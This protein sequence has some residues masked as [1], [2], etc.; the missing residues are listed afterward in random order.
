MIKWINTDLPKYEDPDIEIIE[1]LSVLNSI[2]KGRIAFDYETTG[3]KP[4]ATGH[5]IICASVADSSD[6]AFVFMM[7]STRKERQP[8]ID[9]LKNPNVGK[10]AQNMKFE[11]A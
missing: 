3:I 10:M 11:H 8:F 6:H 9:L 1:D 2:K 7:P 5:R 4:H